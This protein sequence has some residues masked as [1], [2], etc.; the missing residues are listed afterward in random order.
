MVPGFIKLLLHYLN[1]LMEA[2]QPSK[3]AIASVYAMLMIERI[4]RGLPVEGMETGPGVEEL[5][6]WAA[7]A[8]YDP[9]DV[10]QVPYGPQEKP[11]H[12]WFM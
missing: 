5:V 2:P 11:P 12:G 9:N 7:T 10:E 8:S 1:N 4:R 3:D 6:K